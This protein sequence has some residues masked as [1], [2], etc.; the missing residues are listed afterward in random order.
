MVFSAIWRYLASPATAL[1]A[2]RMSVGCAENASIPLTLIQHL[3]HIDWL[4]SLL[5]ERCCRK[6]TKEHS[7]AA[8]ASSLYMGKDGLSGKSEYLLHHSSQSP[9]AIDNRRLTLKHSM[10]S[11]SIWRRPEA[12]LRFSARWH[13][14]WLTIGRCIS[15]RLNFLMM[16]RH[17]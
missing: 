4:D 6:E 2:K 8:G 13:N 11:Y 14:T 9:T 10:V 17:R 15:S 7:L 3:R 1:T 12:H 16:L 5:L